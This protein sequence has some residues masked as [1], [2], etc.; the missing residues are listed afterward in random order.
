MP[1]HI[2]PKPSHLEKLF[3]H[4]HTSEQSIRNKTAHYTVYTFT[5][6]FRAGGKI[7]RYFQTTDADILNIDD[8]TQQSKNCQMHFFS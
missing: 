8:V 7:S 5:C 1:R 2:K 4:L 6:M 3:G